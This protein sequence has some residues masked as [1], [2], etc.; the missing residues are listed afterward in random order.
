MIGTQCGTSTLATTV[1]DT[2]RAHRF[3]FS[4]FVKPV[5]SFIQ[6]LGVE[7]SCISVA[8]DGSRVVPFKQSPR[9]AWLCSVPLKKVPGSAGRVSAKIKLTTLLG[10][11]WR[12]S[13]CEFSVSA[14]AQQINKPD[15]K[16]A[17][18]LWF[19]RCARRRLFSPLGVKIRNRMKAVE[20]TIHNFRSICDAIIS[21][22]E[23]GVLVG[24]NN[25]GKTTVIDAIRAFYG[26][27]GKFDKS[28][29]MPFKHAADNES[30]VEIEFKPSDEEFENLKEEYR[31]EVKT[32]RVRNYL[33]SEEKGERGKW[34]QTRM[35]LT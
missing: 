32:F 15:A 16:P 28:K 19:P 17:A 7:A 13:H 21:L 12:S 5:N 1:L 4:G 26:K 33:Y 31:S 25:A 29:D 20:I 9:R 6:S 23:F 8:L 34:G 10:R 18:R 3:S 35:A 11:V 30:W 2:T 22:H 14:G 24:V 27:G